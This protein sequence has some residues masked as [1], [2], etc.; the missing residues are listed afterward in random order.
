[1]YDR[2]NPTQYKNTH[3]LNINIDGNKIRDVKKQK[4]LGVYIDEN[5][6]WTDHIDHFAPLSNLN[7]IIEI[8]FYIYPK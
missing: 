6:C 7:F 5:L 4:L 2:R 8:T 1:M 3:S